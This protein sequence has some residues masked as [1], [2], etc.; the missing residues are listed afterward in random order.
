MVKSSINPK[1][2][3]KETADIEPDDLKYESFPY[4]IIFDSI[5]PDNPVQVVFGQLQTLYENDGV[6]HFPMYFLNNKNIASK[7]GVLEIEKLKKLDIFEGGDGGEIIPDV[8]NIVMYSFVN[9]GYLDLLDGPPS[10]DESEDETETIIESDESDD[11]LFSVRTSKVPTERKSIFTVDIHKKQVATLPEE[12]KEDAKTI[13]KAYNM[14][15]SDD[16]IVKFMKNKHYKIHEAD[17]CLFSVIFHAFNEIGENITCDKVRSLLADELT[18][19]MFQDRKRAYLEYVDILTENSKIIV[20]GKKSMD[21]M[22]KRVKSN[23][24]S[25]EERRRIVDEAKKLKQTIVDRTASNRDLELFAKQNLHKNFLEMRDVN[26]FGQY[27]DFV[28]STKHAVEESDIT[29]LEHLLSVKFIILSEDSYRE[30]SMDSVLECGKESDVRFSPNFYI[31]VSKSKHKYSLVTYKDKKLLTFREIPYDIKML[32]MNKCMERNSGNYNYIQDFRNMKSRMGIPIDD[33]DASEDYAINSGVEHD[34]R[35]VFVL[36]SESQDK[37]PPGCGCGEH[38]PTE[39]II[40]YIQ[41]D[42]VPHW[43]KKLDDSWTE[44]PFVLDG[45]K[46]ASVDNKYQGAKYRNSY[47]EFSAQFSSDSNSEFSKDPFLAKIVGGKGKHPLKP[48]HVKHVDK[49]FYGERS[50]KEK[51]NGLIAKFEQNLDMAAML[52]ATRPATLMQFV[53]GKKP[54]IRYDLMMVR[55]YLASKNMR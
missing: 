18:D 15:S 53:R 40:Q 44:A 19:E 11:G 6:S 46:W 14:A 52:L 20:G 22:K 2:E 10:D 43:R 49:D 17:D 27:Q 32:V 26:S 37:V 34:P 42:K 47:P 36:D 25:T 3:Y 8:K 1:V 13:R 33:I 50:V 12:T 30:H 23:D 51:H 9:K 28:K 35:I 54:E 21:V 29:L 31:I 5:D 7:I 16:W 41:L 39:K 55:D 4:S 45:H 48:P 38:I 24:V